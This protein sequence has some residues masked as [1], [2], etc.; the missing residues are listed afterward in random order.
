VV[1]S[2]TEL[3][4]SWEAASCAVAQE[5]SSILWNPEVHYRVH[6]SPPLIPI[7]SQIDPIHTMPSYLTV[8][9]SDNNLESY[10]TIKWL[11]EIN[12]DWYQQ[13]SHVVL[14]IV[15]LPTVFHP[16]CSNLQS[17][18]I[19][20][21]WFLARGFFYPENGGHTFLRNIGSYKIYM[22]PHPRRR[23]SS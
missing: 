18:A 6:K 23:H 11:Q 22:A 21:C 16:W 15:S 2:L 1:H 3:S 9:V 17:A 5:L 10:Y 20:S 13:K 4:P 12:V 19:C 7:L 8:V 14:S